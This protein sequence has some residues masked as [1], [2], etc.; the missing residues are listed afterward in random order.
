VPHLTLRALDF[1]ALQRDLLERLERHLPELGRRYDA[2]KQ[3]ILAEARMVLGEP[4]GSYDEL[5]PALGHR[6]A[7]ELLCV[8][9][10][11]DAAGERRAYL[12]RMVAGLLRHAGASEPLPE[13]LTRSA[14]FTRSFGLSHPQSA[15]GVSGVFAPARWWDGPLN[16][17][18]LAEA[19]TALRLQDPERHSLTRTLHELAMRFKGRPSEGL[20][21]GVEWVAASA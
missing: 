6:Y 17:E 15:L 16:E 9:G 7:P 11:V 10:E 13:A 18:K 14:L 5:L 19:L 3:A 21:V 8:L 20:L 2:T 4:L 1:E 12:L